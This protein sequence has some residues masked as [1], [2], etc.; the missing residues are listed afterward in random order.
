MRCVCMLCLMHLRCGSSGALYRGLTHAFLPYAI[1]N[2]TECN[3]LCSLPALCVGVS[4]H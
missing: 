1:G 4:A 3:G 2:D